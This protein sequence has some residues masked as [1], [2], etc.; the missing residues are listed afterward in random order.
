M[1]PFACSHLLTGVNAVAG[2]KFRLTIHNSVVGAG[3]FAFGSNLGFSCRGGGL[4]GLDN[5]CGKRPVAADRRVSIT[6]MNTTNL[7]RGGNMACLVRK[8]PMNMFCLPRYANVSR[9][10]RCVVRS[11]SSGNAVSANSDNSHGMYKRTVPGCF[12]N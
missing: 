3:S 4:G 1:P 12:L 11:L 8:R 7:M 9:G 6:A 10:K 2:V 5:A